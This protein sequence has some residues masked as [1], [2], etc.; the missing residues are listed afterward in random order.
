MA[1][2]EAATLATV[3]KTPVNLENI[4]DLDSAWRVCQLLAMSDIV[5]VP[6]RNKPANVLLVYMTGRELGLTFAQALRTI[7]IAPGGS[8]QLRGSLLLALLRR[9]G[10]DY[11]FEY[12]EGSCTTTVTRGDTGGKF[13]AT[14]TLDDAEAA[15]LVKRNADG[16]LVAYSSSNR[17]L[18]WMTYQRNMLRWRSVAEAANI[19]APEV[20]MGFDLMDYAGPQNERPDLKPAAAPAAADEGHQPPAAGSG[21]APAAELAS[22]DARGAAASPGEEPAGEGTSTPPPPAAE[23]PSADPRSP[24]PASEQA[25]RGKAGDG[26]RRASSAELARVSEK[27]GQIGWTYFDN[28]PE[29]LNCLTVRCRRVIHKPGDLSGKEASAVAQDLSAILRQNDA[30][31]LVALSDAMDGWEHDWEQADPEGYERDYTGGD[32]D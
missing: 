7:Y 32:H 19:A 6:L 11:E 12:A 29:I 28:K 16:N 20:M 5:P 10:H 31:Y 27:F 24:S 26:N 23:A 1:N 17:K 8:P 15:E 2:T 18:P 14:F 4:T 9:A 22:L 21:E 30:E 13:P 25:Q 3:P